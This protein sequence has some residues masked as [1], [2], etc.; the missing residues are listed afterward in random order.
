MVVTG[1]RSVLC[2]PGVK[3]TPFNC[4]VLMTIGCRGADGFF[5][6]VVTYSAETAVVASVN[7]VAPAL[8]THARM[9]D[10]CDRRLKEGHSVERGAEDLAGIGAE[11]AA[12]DLLV[13]GAEIDRVLEVAGRIES[14]EA[15]RRTI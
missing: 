6:C 13:N 12:Q 1:G 11:M 15:W 3:V 10:R 4:A 14:G 5:R 7:A 8:S 2:T 9:S